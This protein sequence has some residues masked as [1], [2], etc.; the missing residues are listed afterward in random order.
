MLTILSLFSCQILA[1]L[2]K[3]SINLFVIRIQGIDFVMGEIEEATF[4]LIII[5]N[6]LKSQWHFF[7]SYEWLST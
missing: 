2:T 4:C 3:R 6:F 1:V 7:W 5:K